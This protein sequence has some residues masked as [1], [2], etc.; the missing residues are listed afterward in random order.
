MKIVVDQKIPFV[1]E[2]FGGFGELLKLD[3]LAI[4]NASLRDANALIVRS[5]TR[6]NEQLLAGSRVEFVGTATIGTD[7]V[8]SEFLRRNG[9]EF[10]SAPG[11]NAY[12]VMQYVAAAL[13]T[14]SGRS[15]QTLR[16]KTLGVVGVGNVG[17][18]VVRLGQALGMSVLQ[19]D[20]PLARTTGEKRF[21]QLDELMEADFI[22]IHVP[23]TRTGSDPTYHLFDSKRIAS[24]KSGGV[25]INSSRGSVVDNKALK[26]ALNT[27]RIHAAVLDVWENE[28]NIDVDLLSICALGTP[29]IAGYSIDGKVNATRMIYDAFC[30]HFG[31]PRKWDASKV[32]PLPPN[33]EIIIDGSCTSFDE[34]LRRIVRYT[35]DIERDDMELRKIRTVAEAERGKFFKRLRGNYKFRYEFTNYTVS[36]DSLAEEVKGTLSALGF[37]CKG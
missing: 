15:G 9:I 17:S 3:S 16:G 2:A 22:T 24:M 36:C 13:L 19:N 30:R 21:V 27:G 34:M 1:D 8:D 20:P 11:C 28:P 6:V 14:L 23:L 33:P 7:H 12:A 10:A 35:Y 18:K 31:F 37:N 5:E 29:H 25:L 4:D 32:V 26:E